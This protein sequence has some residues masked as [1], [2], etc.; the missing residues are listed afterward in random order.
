MPM[1]FACNNQHYVRCP[2]NGFVFDQTFFCEGASGI[3]LY[4]KL[5]LSLSVS[6]CS[7]LLRVFHSCDSV[8]LK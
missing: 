4:A 1:M 7:G 3:K 8:V 6:G 2:L 5:S